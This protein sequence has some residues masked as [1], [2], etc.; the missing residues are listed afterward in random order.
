MP[1]R[2]QDFTC[3]LVNF[4]FSIVCA[5]ISAHSR[6]PIRLMSYKNGYGPKSLSFCGVNFSE[7]R[8]GLFVL[9]RLI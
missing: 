6:L 8:L 3:S 9:F 1:V 7:E 2:P 4:D 5:S